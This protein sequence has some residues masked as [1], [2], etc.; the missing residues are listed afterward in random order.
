MRLGQA[1]GENTGEIVIAGN[2]V[3]GAY[4]YGGSNYEVLQIIMI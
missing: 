3:I 2:N 4:I 1:I